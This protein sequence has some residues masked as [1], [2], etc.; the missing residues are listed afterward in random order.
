MF[1][2]LFNGKDV[3]VGIKIGIGK[4][5]IYEYVLVLF[6]NGIIVNNVYWYGSR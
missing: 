2:V 3:F 5:M 4:L 1:I 6:E